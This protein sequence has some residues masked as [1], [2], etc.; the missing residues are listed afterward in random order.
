MLGFLLARTGV[1]VAVPEK[2]GD[3]LR[4]FRGNTIHPSTLD[5]MYELG[6]LDEFLKRPHQ[7]VREFAGQFGAYRVPIAFHSIVRQTGRIQGLGSGCA[8]GRVV[9]ADQPPV[10]RSEPDLRPLR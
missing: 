1:E 10:H 4:D 8:D 7:E 3:F 9:D 5:L 6:L 2:H